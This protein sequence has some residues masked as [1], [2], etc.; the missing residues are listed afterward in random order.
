[1]C[2][3]LF[4]EKC[5]PT[6]KKT[7]QE[8]ISIMFSVGKNYNKKKTPQQMPAGRHSGAVSTIA[9]QQETWVFS[10]SPHACVGCGFSPGTLASSQNPKTCMYVRLIGNSKLVEGGNMSLNSCL[11]L[12]VRFVRNQQHVGV[13]PYGRWDWLQHPL[14]KN[15]LSKQTKKPFNGNPPISFSDTQTLPI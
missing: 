10:C 8:N 4:A 12:C 13:S 1:M 2:K 9:S 7:H 15:Q 5:I 14:S 6:T 11:S 3:L